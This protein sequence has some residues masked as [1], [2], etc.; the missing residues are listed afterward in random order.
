MRTTM[1][2]TITISTIS[3]A[4]TEVKNGSVEVITHEP[5]TVVGKVTERTVNKHVPS[6]ALVTSISYTEN[7][8]TMDLEKFIEVAELVSSEKVNADSKEEQQ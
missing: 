3:Y 6:G 4:T 5:I 7:N 8:Y 2:R 1:Q